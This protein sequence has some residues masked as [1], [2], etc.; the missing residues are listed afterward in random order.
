[1]VPRLIAT[2]L[3]AACA[4]AAAADFDA[5]LDAAW[6][7]YP[8]APADPVQHSDPWSIE[9][10]ASWR[11][12]G[13][14]RWA[15]S[16]VLSWDRA[17]SA[18][19]ADL[20]EAHWQI[21][22]RRW[23]LRMGSDTVF[24]GVTESRHLVDIVNQIDTRRDLYGNVRL[25]QP[26]LRWRGIG[27]RDTVDLLLLPYF[28]E[29]RWPEP[30]GGLR[31][32]PAVDGGAARFEADEGR[33]HLDLALRWRRNVGALDWALSAFR[34][35]AREPVLNL[36]P[37]GR[38]LLPYYPQIRQLGLELQY[39]R[40]AWLWKLEALERH[41]AFDRDGRRRP[42]RA[43][44]A[45]F[46]YTVFSA[47]GDADLGLL[48]ERLWDERGDAAADPFQDDWFVA[49]RWIGNDLDDQN[50]LPGLVYDRNSG[51]RAWRLDWRR[52][53]GDRWTVHVEG[54]AFRRVAPDGPLGWLRRD[55]HI[56]FALQRHFGG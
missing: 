48:L 56:G 5:R 1:M 8:E 51:E 25:G 49:L 19:W 17:G 29:R 52:R 45:G 54:A 30:E 28:R 41:G 38:R 13:E 53:L 18:L 40:G 20:P 37:D 33:R 27:R 47:L 7:H 14:R 3:G 26:M 2:L 21:G 12:G 55:D 15:L 11:G 36:A 23:W 16:A 46:E 50:A 6:R 39:T 10:R 22:G 4:A 35:T 43:A 32:Q 44:V 34:G 9:A 31:P 24:W 42:Y